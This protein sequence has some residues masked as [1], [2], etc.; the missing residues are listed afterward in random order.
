MKHGGQMKDGMQ[1]KQ[2]RTGRTGGASRAGCFCTFHP[3]ISCLLVGFV[4]MA[5]TI[6]FVG[7]AGCGGSGTPDVGSDLMV[8]AVSDVG[9]DGDFDAGFDAHFDALLDTRDGVVADASDVVA[10]VVVTPVNVTFDGPRSVPPGSLV[11]VVVTVEDPLFTGDLDILA[12]DA[13]HTIGV[14]R[15]R[16]SIAVTAP[17]VAGNWTLTVQQHGFAGSQQVLVETRPIR[18]ISGLL[19][20][21]DLSWDDTSDILVEANAEV[22]AGDTLTVAVGTRVKFAAKVRLTVKGKLEVQGT[23]ASPVWFLPADKAW[24]EIDVVTPVSTG[25]LDGTAVLSWTWL[26]GGGGDASRAF[27]HSN[28]QPVVRA[29]KGTT[30]T[31]TGGGMTDS[32]GKAFGSQ[33]AT[34]TIEDALISRCDTGGEHKASKV[35]VS[36]CHIIQIPD[37]DGVANDEDNDGIYLND[38][39]GTGPECLVEDSVFYRGE[40]DAIDHNGAKLTINRVWINSFA[41]EGLAASKGRDVW[42]R[43]TMISGCQQGIEAGYGAPD[44]HVSNCLVTGNEVGLRWGDSYEPP[45]FISSGTM[46]VYDTVSVNNS[47]NNVLFWDDQ[48][49]D[50]PGDSVSIACSMV[51]SPEWDNLS[52]NEGGIPTW[53]D[54]GCIN[55]DPFS[56]HFESCVF[57]GPQTGTC[58]E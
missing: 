8:D 19:A 39:N 54:W 3:G 21:A 23:A 37:G 38:T 14:A 10:D 11:P 15:G 47:K 6:G 16:G 40:D 7:V 51:D 50:A 44:V 17:S 12:G 35:T 2:G 45:D 25:G 48:Q 55:K 26:T 33:S 34:V 57:L 24:G 42:I 29:Q 28:S 4:V 53:N 36:R 49:G 5:G 58:A 46:N 18:T 56:I 22:P 41:H 31:L 43:N 13:R 32:P 1:M 52:D 27:G 20:G 9:A 30:V